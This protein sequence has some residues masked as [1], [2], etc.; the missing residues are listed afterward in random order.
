MNKK[1][2]QHLKYWLDS[3]ISLIH[4]YSAVILGKL[5]GGWFWWLVWVYVAITLVYTLRRTSKL[6]KDYLSTKEKK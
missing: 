3:E 5:F 4:I 6:P 1:D 2:L